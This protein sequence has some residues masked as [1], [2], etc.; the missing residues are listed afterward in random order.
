MAGNLRPDAIDSYVEIGA[1]ES[2]FPLQLLSTVY[3]AYIGYRD[4]LLWPAFNK[5]SLNYV[6]IIPDTCTVAPELE[7]EPADNLAETDIQNAADILS[8]DEADRTITITVTSSDG[9]ANMVYTVLLRLATGLA[10]LDTLY[11]CNG[12]LEPAFDPDA[13]YYTAWLPEGTTEV[14][15]VYYRTSDPYATVKVDKA[16]EIGEYTYIRI[17]ATDNKKKRIYGIKFLIDESDGTKDFLQYSLIV[18]PNPA[19]SQ[20]TVKMKHNKEIHKI[21]IL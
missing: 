10:T 1:Y 5:D 3:L 6:Q 13:F 7:I 18:Y 4:F 16:A 8:Q 2:P 12:L 20:L 21:D 14:P 11:L 19:V 9:T 17:T 15:D